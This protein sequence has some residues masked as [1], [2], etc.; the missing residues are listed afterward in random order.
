MWPWIGLG[1][2]LMLFPGAVL[3][4]AEVG[5]IAFHTH[6]FLRTQERLDIGYATVFRRTLLVYLSEN[7]RLIL[8]SAKGGPVGTRLD[9]RRDD[10][11]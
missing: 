6:L 4:L 1:V 5:K 9:V 11:D 8:R 10:F 3:C 2:G 7:M